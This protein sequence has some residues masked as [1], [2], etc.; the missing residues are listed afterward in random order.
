MRQGTQNI[1]ALPWLSRINDGSPGTFRWEEQEVSAG[2][3]SGSISYKRGHFS[4][5]RMT[6]EGK[7]MAFISILLWG[8]VAKVSSICCKSCCR[9]LQKDNGHRQCQKAC[10]YANVMFSP[11]VVM[12][13]QCVFN[14]Q[15]NLLRVYPS[16]QE[17][18]CVRVCVHG[19]WAGGGCC[20][21]IVV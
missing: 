15:H 8:M 13:A 19:E 9:S 2:W 7:A 3:F 12:A 10:I 4:P 1:K 14:F 11:R 16:T 21:V 6:Y 5:Y 18:V 20:K 17:G